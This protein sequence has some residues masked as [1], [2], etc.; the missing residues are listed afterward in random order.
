MA[1]PPPGPNLVCSPI[2]VVLKM[3]VSP[4]QSLFISGTNILAPSLTGHP[5][6]FLPPCTHF[7]PSNHS[8]L[9]KLDPTSLVT[10]LFKILNG[11][12]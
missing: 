6:S 1:S 5:A 11:S 8:D 10:P 4:P 9:E 2:Q 7:L 3:P 12:P